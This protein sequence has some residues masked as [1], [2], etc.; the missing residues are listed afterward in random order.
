MVLPCLGTTYEYICDCDEM[1]IGKSEEEKE[2]KKT[3]LEKGTK[4]PLDEG[5]GG[6]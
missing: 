1:D 5:E 3:L 4:E 2:T 6:E